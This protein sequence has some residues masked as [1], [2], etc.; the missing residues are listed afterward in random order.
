MK[1]SEA[2]NYWV[3]ALS[4]ISTLQYLAKFFYCCCSG[5]KKINP[6]FLQ[7]CNSFV[8]ET[9]L[10]MIKA[11]MHKHLGPLKMSIVKTFKK[12]LKGDGLLVVCC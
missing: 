1:L 6:T 7:M 12:H 5:E 11:S 8:L 10:W 2:L 4:L 3:G 9:W